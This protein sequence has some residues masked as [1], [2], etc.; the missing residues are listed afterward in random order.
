MCS[1]YCSLASCQLRVLHGLSQAI[2][3]DAGDCARGAIRE[4]TFKGAWSLPAFKGAS[5]GLLPGMASGQPSGSSPRATRQHSGCSG[6]T[7]SFQGR[8][9]AMSMACGPARDSALLPGDSQAT[10]SCSSMLSGT[11]CWICSVTQGSANAVPR[12]EPQKASEVSAS[13]CNSRAKGAC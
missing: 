4:P 6:G 9:L 3:P 10:S 2:L 13:A 8:T 1:T 11:T 12:N 5:E 7:S